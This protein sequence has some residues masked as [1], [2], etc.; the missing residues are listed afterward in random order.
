V[1]R[2]FLPIAATCLALASLSVQA[3]EKRLDRTFTVTPGGRLTVEADG[4]DITVSGTDSNQVIVQM[5][6]TGSEKS[7]DAMA[8]S[9]EQEADGVTVKAKRDR[10]GWFNWSS[11]PRQSSIKVTVP[12]RYSARLQTSGGD[13]AL[14]QLQGDVS[15]STSGGDVRVADLQGPLKI[16]TSGGNMDI[17]QVDGKS[18]IRT[19]G[20][21]IKASGIKGG[22]K[23][24]TSGGD[25]QVEQVTGA[26]SVHTSG[27]NVFVSAVQGDVDAQSSGG[28]VKALG[29]NGAIRA[30]S[31]GGDVQVELVGA[32]RGITTST[33]GGNI[34]IR[35]PR[36]TSAQLDAATSGG[37]V[38]SEL[39]V[40]TTEARER[41]LAGTIN[42]GGAPI[43]ARTTGGSIRVQASN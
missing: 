30:S 18:D 9:A 12:R 37:S 28:G 21:D 34:V 6:V 11:G 41:R 24:D 39:P 31:S 10:G 4:A 36:N 13:I 38:S 35:V 2:N 22:L 25:I 7:I 20:G 23:A 14:S 15:G 27:G 33:T 43:H 42:G 26:T 29:V 3:A 16:T 5:L 8:L 19:S 1:I 32:N 17:S 40:T